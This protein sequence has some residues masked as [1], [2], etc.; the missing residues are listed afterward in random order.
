MSATVAAA[1][2]K[3]SAVVLSDKK[4]LKTAVGIIIGIIVIIVMPIAAV[5]SIFSGDMNI[6]TDRLQQMITESLTSEE[7]DNLKFIEDTMLT[8]DE[9]M[10]AAGFPDRVKEAQV[11]YVLVLSDYSRED[12]F[13][14][15]LVG[16]FAADQTD[17]QLILAVNETFG[18]DNELYLFEAPI[19][20]LSYISINKDGWQKH[21]YAAS[22]SVSDRVLFQ[23]LKDNP[24]IQKVYLCLDNDEAGQ[25]ANERI[26]D[27][28][29]IQGIQHEILVPN[30]KD[31]NEDRLAADGNAPRSC[32]EFSVSN[33]NEEEGEEPCQALQL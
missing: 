28:L 25:K 7:E 12:G 1:L 5:L 13:T 27:K 4:N 9:K 31:W 26:S 32:A 3:L 21:S 24:N 14:D 23:M 33:E 19:D 16:C 15:K 8:L 29:F 6:D 2:K 20:L 30:H 22:C 11:L 10:T 18:T 17:E